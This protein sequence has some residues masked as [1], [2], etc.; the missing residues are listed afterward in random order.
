MI[1]SRFSASLSTLLVA[2]A[3]T[4]LAPGASGTASEV[5]SGTTSNVTSGAGP[6]SSEAFASSDRASGGS[7]SELKHLST[8]VT[9][10]E[11]WIPFLGW[12]VVC[13]TTKVRCGPRGSNC[14]VQVQA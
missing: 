10:I 4:L 2:C 12:R 14:P 1:R 13:E 11:V 9:T 3:L 7:R 6:G 8:T 5:T